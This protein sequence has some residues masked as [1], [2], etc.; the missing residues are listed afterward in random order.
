MPL[1]RHPIHALF[2][3]LAAALVAAAGPAGA[4]RADRSKPLTVEADN[5]SRLDI[6]KQVVTFNGNVVVTKGTMLMRAERLEVRE[7]PDG[8][9]H[10]IATGAPGKPATFRQKR[11]G[12]DEF[13]EGQADRIEYDGRADTV[14][15]IGAAQVRRLRGTAVA[16]E[17]SGALITYDNMN[18]VFSVAGGAATPSNPSGRVRAVLMPREAA[19]AAAAS[20]PPL[21]PSERIGEP[22]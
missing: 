5:P 6:L 2:T 8:Y 18:E 21:K 4:E 14:R 11:D 13:V 12:G 9:H 22:R 19:G 15:F 17:V 3:S 16:D 7:T 10:A 1:M 20:A